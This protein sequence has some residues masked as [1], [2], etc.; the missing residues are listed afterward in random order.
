MGG[1]LKGGKKKNQEAEQEKK[2]GIPPESNCLQQEI[3][4]INT[5]WLLKPPPTG[6]SLKPTLL[7]QPH[8]GRCYVSNTV[9]SSHNSAGASGLLYGNIFPKF[10]RS[11]HSNERRLPSLSEY[12]RKT[13]E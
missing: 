6:A 5:I 4:Y 13:E 7:L 9:K 10:P 2:E 12:H 11:K 3:Q 8:G 1:K